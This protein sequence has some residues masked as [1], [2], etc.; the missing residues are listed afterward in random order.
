LNSIAGDIPDL[1]GS[2]RIVPPQNCHIT[3]KFL[4]DTSDDQI[5][6]MIPEIAKQVVQYEPFSFTIAGTGVFPNR[7]RPR[8]LWLGITDGYELL[9][10]IS[11]EIDQITSEFG[12]APED[13][14]FRA[15]VTFGRVKRHGSSVAG[16]D[17][18]LAYDY[19]PLRNDVDSV[20]FQESILTPSGA[21]YKPLYTFNINHQE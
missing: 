18:F 20:I 3:L 13:R 5:E 2:V 7:R 10:K 12:F 19:V 15:H 1:K 14:Q 17:S 4:G 9:R 11:S 16:L 6:A 8:V 21:I